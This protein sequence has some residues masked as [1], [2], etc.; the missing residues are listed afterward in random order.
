LDISVL[1]DVSGSLGTTPDK[2]TT[3]HS[4]MQNL[5]GMY[6]TVNQ[7]KLQI[8]SFSE[9]GVVDLPMGFYNEF[10]IAAGV[11]SI[12]WQ[13]SYTNI[14]A[15][16]EASYADL[17]TTDSVQ[18]IM[19]I[20]TD[21]FHSGSTSSM[22]AQLDDIKNDGVRVIA[23]G[24]FGQFAFYSPNLFLMTN[25]VYHAANYTELLAIDTTI[26]DTICDDGAIHAST[27]AK[28]V[29]ATESD[30]V[31]LQAAHDW[32]EVYATF[33]VWLPEEWRP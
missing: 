29:S 6:D 18:D 30:L 9:F 11:D 2:D 15:G 31:L 4:F 3:I 24:F 1:V 19:I 33:P 10:E 12:N 32:F 21:G 27:V 25:E 13:G 20:I 5:A 14:T 22:F 17:D 7:V 23:L 16:L 28:L 26:F 8:T